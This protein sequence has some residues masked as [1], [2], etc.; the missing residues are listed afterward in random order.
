MER[1]DF[2]QELAYNF[3][4]YSCQM[5]FGVSRDDLDNCTAKWNMALEYAYQEWLDG[6]EDGE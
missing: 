2:M 4:E 5:Y 1:T 3:D 6:M